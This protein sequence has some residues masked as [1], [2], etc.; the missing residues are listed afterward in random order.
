MAGA[1][2]VTNAKN[3]ACL[4][5]YTYNSR[6]DHIGGSLLFLFWI[7]ILNALLYFP[8]YRFAGYLPTDSVL[9]VLAFH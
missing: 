5:H 7:K 1:M 6:L 8:F 2:L 3:G 9:R 4:S